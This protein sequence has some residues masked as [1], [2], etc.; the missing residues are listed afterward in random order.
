VL[1]AQA[2]LICAPRRSTLPEASDLSTRQRDVLHVRERVRTLHAI[3]PIVRAAASTA[4][5]RAVISV[6]GEE[7]RARLHCIQRKK[8]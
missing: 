4:T 3:T 8:R 7:R 1:S 2:P 5:I 6:A